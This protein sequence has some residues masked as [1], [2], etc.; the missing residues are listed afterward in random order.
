MRLFLARPATRDGRWDPRGGH[1]GCGYVL[2][3]N[4]QAGGPAGVPD[5]W[6]PGY[7]LC[8]VMGSVVDCVDVDTQKGGSLDSL[9]IEL[10][11][12]YGRAATP[13]G[14]EHLLV[15]SLGVRSR[16]GIAQGVDLKAG[17]VEG[18]G[19][20][21]IFIAPTVKVSKATGVP[22]QYRWTEPPALAALSVLGGDGS[23]VGLAD[24]VATLR[25]KRRPGASPLAA[26]PWTDLTSG[27]QAMA[28]Q[29][30]RMVVRRWAE[31][32]NLAGEWEEHERDEEGRGWETLARDAAWALA[33]L[34]AAPWT[35]LDEE[36]GGELYYQ[37]LPS[38]MDADERCTGKWYPG[39]VEKAAE[40][41]V[42][43]PP[44]VGLSAVAEEL[45]DIPE[46]TD[47]AYMAPWMLRKGLDSNWC[48]A[49][50][51]GWMCWDGRRWASRRDEDLREAVRLASVDLTIRVLEHMDELGKRYCKEIMTLLEFRKLRDLSV[52]MRGTASVDPGQFDQQPDL[53]NCGN[54][55][56]DLVTGE[57]L[58]WRKDWWMTKA[59]H[60]P[61]VAGA[62]HPDF[63]QVLECLELPVR[64]WMQ[65]RFG[66]AATGWPTSDDVLP[67]GQGG[68]SNGKTTLLAA[69]F[70]ALGE[71]MTLVPEK[72][73][74][75]SPSDH[76]TELMTLRGVRLA[77]I[78]E[79]PE[80]AQLNV[81]RLKATVGTPRIT[82]RAIRQDNVSWQATH[83]LCVMTN[84][85]PSVAETDHGTWRRLAL[86]RFDRTFPR[87]DAFKARVEHGAGGR[88]EACLAWVVEGARRWY[89]AGRVIDRMP[90]KVEHDTR[91]WRGENDLVLLYSGERLIFD[92]S[93]AITVGDLADDLNGWLKDRRQRPWSDKLVSSRFREHQSIAL[94]GVAKTL[95][96]SPKNV[97]DRSGKVEDRDGA[98]LRLWRGLGFR[99]PMDV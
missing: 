98:M 47:D 59:T 1:N 38:A 33:C 14:G 11:K 68:G 67:V 19:R 57:L 46:R 24:Y 91:E 17:D 32:L 95:E 27:Q 20:G 86:V 83:S 62:S 39:I 99:E 10:P 72:L 2:P 26:V 80:V 31:K 23:G 13:S 5:R 65:M 28:A 75:A 82:A 96:R 92:P 93:A 56:V 55:V 35:S 15:A 29:H 43:D 94:A 61:Y 4:W 25:R 16:D 73:L 21:F 18:K 90:E 6:K 64:K 85:T 9:D 8:A 34:T 49:G 53:L 50:G 45:P 81:P 78:D 44:W 52:L 63:D 76:P 58:D 7:A 71:H 36:S 54:G 88:S 89:R 48:W 22:V 41:G 51:L 70:G 77:V 69:L 74:R 40:E 60:V 87:D 12:V 79:T 3:D 84:Y 30:V 42:D 66:Q 97:Y 37:I